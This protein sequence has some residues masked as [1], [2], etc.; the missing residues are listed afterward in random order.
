MLANADVVLRAVC[1][2][3]AFHLNAFFVLAVDSCAGN[4]VTVGSD[5]A[6]GSVDACVV[7]AIGSVSSIRVITVLAVV[8]AG[9]WDV[10]ALVVSAKRSLGGPAA[11]SVLSAFLLLAHVANAETLSIAALV[12]F[13]KGTRAVADTFW[14]VAGVVRLSAELVRFAMVVAGTL[15][16]HAFLLD[17]FVSDQASINEEVRAVLVASAFLF[18]TFSRFAKFFRTAMRLVSTLDFFAFVILAVELSSASLVALAFDRNA[19]VGLSFLWVLARADLV[20]LVAVGV[21]S[22]VNGGA[23]VCFTSARAIFAASDFEAVVVGSAVDGNT[24]VCFASL[25][26]TT[27]L[28]DAASLSDALVLFAEAVSFFTTFDG[29]AHSMASALDNFACVGLSVAELVGSAVVVVSALLFLAVVSH[30]FV[31]I[32]VEFLAISVRV[33]VDLVA[34]VVDADVV[35][36]IAGAVFMHSALD[37]FTEVTDAF[38]GICGAK[39]GAVVVGHA[40]DVNALVAILLAAA[41]LFV[42]A[43]LACSAID[44]DANVFLAGL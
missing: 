21:I 17:T 16:V 27:V 6:L 1:V 26:K 28:V 3:V 19:L 24:L 41:D 36:V 38:V 15:D 14:L 8:V 9:A 23:A 39:V 29:V 31:G 4:G 42:A 34:N 18:D 13:V 25:L 44:I 2:S 43:V 40:L 35:S 11:V 32:V 37:C 10:L 33:A 12:G 22:A 20:L 30:A 5:E 7:L